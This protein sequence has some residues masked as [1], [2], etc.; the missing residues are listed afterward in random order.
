[1]SVKT[2]MASHA[3]STHYVTTQLGLSSVC[4]LLDINPLTQAVR[5]STNAS[6]T[7]PVAMTRCA[8]TCLECTTALAHWVTTRSRELVLT[9]MNVRIPL[10]TPWHTAG[11]HLGPTHVTAILA[12]LEMGLGAKTLMSA[13]P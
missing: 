11:T 1:M 6:T 7:P 5:I 12:S 8:L 2:Q 13:S 9:T 3:Q 4:A 10:A